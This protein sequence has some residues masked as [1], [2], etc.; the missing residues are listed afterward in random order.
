MHDNPYAAPLE[1]GDVPPP[2]PSRPQPLSLLTQWLLVTAI[3]GV[4][5][6]LLLPAVQAAREAASR[7]SQCSNGLK[8]PMPPN[9]AASASKPPAAPTGQPGAAPPS[10]KNVARSAPATAV[11]APP[12][13]SK[14]PSSARVVRKAPLKKNRGIFGI[15]KRWVQRET[16]PFV[17]T[18]MVVAA[19]CVLVVV[20][21]PAE[22]RVRDEPRI[23]AGQRAPHGL[24][25][26]PAE[27]T[28]HGLHGCHR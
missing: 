18:C 10:K 26:E 7:R 15:A 22:I 12:R 17:V 19:A 13:I 9:W 27:D 1:P 14:R 8:L 23:F 24:K 4:L 21:L 2:S 11:A 6:A 20:L 3:Y 16:A 28:N 25:L 5:A